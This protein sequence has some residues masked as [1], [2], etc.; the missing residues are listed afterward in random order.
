M[1]VASSVKSPK[2]CV[3]IFHQKSVSR[4][5]QQNGVVE[6]QNRTLVEEARTMLV[7][8]K[9]LMFLWA[10]AVATVCYTQNRSLIHTRHNK[11]PYK[12]VRDKKPD[13][14]FLYVFCALCYPMN[15]SEDLGKLRPTADI[16]I[17]VGYAPNKKGYR[18]YNKRTRQ[19]MET[20]HVQFKELTEPMAPVHISKGLEPILL[21]SGQISSGLV[22]DLVPTAPYVSPTNKDLEILFQPMFNEYFEPIGVERPV[23]PASTVQVL[24][25]SSGTPSSTTID[26]DASSTS[27]SRSSS[28]QP[29]ISHQGVVAGPTIKDNPFAQA[30]NDPF[31]NVFSPE[32]SESSSRDVSSAES[33][34]IVYP[35]N[36]LGKWSKDHT[37]YNESFASVA[38][39][40]AIRIFI[41]NFAIKNMIIYQMDVKISFLNGVLKEE[42]YVSQPEG[43]I[44]PDHV[45]YVYRLKKALYG[46][47]Q[48]PKVWYNTLSRF[49]LDNKFPSL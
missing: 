2:L 31:V 12:L 5:S 24:V 35:H 1:V 3:G 21:M 37:L 39:T 17:F 44:D 18:I 20:I 29:P 25:V 38:W 33:T 32:P 8:S 45:T 47:K 14:T 11:T 15:D 9:A 13:L 6:R 23:P 28:V 26:Q 10:E 48:A 40:E 4:T 19:I 46:L 42:V 43:F 34:Q 7:F 22:P 41:A 49:L 16:G 27:Y 36:H 30:D